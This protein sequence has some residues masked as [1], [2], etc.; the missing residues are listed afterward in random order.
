MSRLSV[1]VALL[2]GLAPPAFARMIIHTVRQGDTLE[3]LSAEYYGNRGHAVYIMAVNNFTH[4]RPL[5]PGMRLK[6]PTAWHYKLK[7]AESLA[8]V[9]EVYVGDK[10]RASFLAQFSGYHSVEEVRPG[11]DVVIPF[12]LTHEAQSAETLGMV[13]AAYYGDS[14]KGDLLREYNFRSSSRLDRGERVLIPIVHVKV[15]ES[16]MPKMGDV[17]A[18]EVAARRATSARVAAAI[19]DAERLYREGKFAEVA[20]RLVRILMEEDP[21]EDEIAQIQE[22]LASCY[23]ALD[24]Q[25]LAVRA[26]REV[27]ARQPKIA[28]DPAEVSPKIRAALEE[29]RKPDGS[30]H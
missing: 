20:T 13:A 30:L 17:A 24:Q 19:E 14:R 22:L 21:S 9:A 6:I 15:R 2:C 5:R 18:Q 7:K 4:P 10:R 1:V 12:H 16:K 26:F 23:V 8:R 25:D 27:L 28:L 29:A 11:Q 3:L